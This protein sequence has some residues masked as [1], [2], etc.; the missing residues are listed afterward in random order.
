MA[1]IAFLHGSGYLADD[2][3]NKAPIVRH[4]D[5]KHGVYVASRIKKEVHV[6]PELR[7][8]AGEKL[9]A[10]IVAAMDEMVKASKKYE[11]IY[12]S[13]YLNK[14]YSAAEVRE[15][16]EWLGYSMYYLCTFDKDFYDRTNRQDPR[17]KFELVNF[18]AGMTLF[19]R[20]FY[21][22]NDIRALYTYLEDDAFTTAAYYVALRLGLKIIGVNFAKFPK[23]GLWMRDNFKDVYVWNDRIADWNE[24]EPLYKE[25]QMTGKWLM[26]KHASYYSLSSIKNRIRGLR[27]SINYRRYVDHVCRRY[28]YDRNIIACTTIPREFKKYFLGMVRRILMKTMITEPDPNAEYVLFGLHFMN[29]AQITFREP[30]ADQIELIM[31]VA[32]ALPSSCLLYVKPHPHRLGSDVSHKDM[33]RLKKVENIRIVN[34]STLPQEM[35]KNAKAVVTINSGIGFEALLA[36]KPV[37]AFGHEFYCRDDLCHVVRD[38]NDLPGALER[39]VSGEKGGDTGRIR[40]IVRRMYSNVVWFKG[41]FYEYG[42]SGLTD[43]D[44]EGMARAMGSILDRYCSG[45]K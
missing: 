41:I 22:D 26:K 4:L 30:M 7:S 23:R 36:G 6:G 11:F 35:L 20:D 1:N 15:I 24:L 31:N 13:P 42:Y 44:G 43:S 29:D 9:Y 38:L 17:D 37:V 5:P 39:A 8:L 10:D 28:P 27:F 2:V 3:L 18:M 19:F 33:K 12:D 32:R 40:E 14:K 34:P 25:G 45:S 16:E 21:R